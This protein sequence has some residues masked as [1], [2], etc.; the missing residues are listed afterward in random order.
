MKLPTHGFVDR[1]LGPPATSVWRDWPEKTGN[2]GSA[3]V[4]L[5]SALITAINTLAQMTSLSTG[6]RSL[7]FL[8]RFV[9]RV[10]EEEPQSDYSPVEDDPFLDELLP[11]VRGTSHYFSVASV[12]RLYTAAMSKLRRM[13]TRVPALF[14]DTLIPHLTTLTEML[15]RAPAD[16]NAER[17]LESQILVVL[18]SLQD[19][20]TLIA[21]GFHSSGPNAAALCRT[22]TLR[23]RVLT[24]A[25]GGQGAMTWVT[26]PD[27]KQLAATVF[28][29]KPPDEE[30]Q[31]KTR[32]VIGDLDALEKASHCDFLYNYK[33]YS[34]FQ[35]ALGSVIP[36]AGFNDQLRNVCVSLRVFLAITYKNTA[37]QHLQARA[38]NAWRILAATSCRQRR[39]ALRRHRSTRQPA[40]G[41]LWQEF[42]A[43]DTKQRRAM[44]AEITSVREALLAVPPVKQEKVLQPRIPIRPAAGGVEREAELTQPKQAK[45]PAIAKLAALN[46]GPSAKATFPPP[47]GT[48]LEYAWR[49]KILDQRRDILVKVRLAWKSANPSP[50]RT[51]EVRPFLPGRTAIGMSILIE[52]A[53]SNGDANRQFLSICGS[54]NDHILTA[55][56]VLAEVCSI[57]TL[58]DSTAAGKWRGIPLIR[59]VVFGLRDYYTKIIEHVQAD[60]ADRFFLYADGIDAVDAVTTLDEFWNDPGVDDDV[61]RTASIACGYTIFDTD[62]DSPKYYLGNIRAANPSTDISQHLKDD[63]CTSAT[64]LLLLGIV[65]WCYNRLREGPTAT[66][67]A[68]SYPFP[69]LGGPDVATYMNSAATNVTRSAPIKTYTPT[70]QELQDR[71][72]ASAIPFR[73]HAYASHQWLMAICDVEAS[74]SSRGYH[75]SSIVAKLSSPLVRS[76]ENIHNAPVIVGPDIMQA[77]IA[78]VIPHSVNVPQSNVRIDKYSSSL[79]WTATVLLAPMLTEVRR[80][81]AANT[82]LLTAAG[83]LRRAWGAFI[84]TRPSTS[85]AAV[86]EMQIPTIQ[87]ISFAMV[88]PLLP[89]GIFD[90]GSSVDSATGAHHVAIRAIIKKSQL[91]ET[92]YTPETYGGACVCA[93]GGDELVGSRKR[94][95][96]G[97]TS[98]YESARDSADRLKQT[99]SNFMQALTPTSLAPRNITSGVTIRSPENAVTLIQICTALLMV[100]PATTNPF[101]ELDIADADQF[102]ERVVATVFWFLTGVGVAPPAADIAE[103]VRLYTGTG[104]SVRFVPGADVKVDAEAACS[105]LASTEGTAKVLGEALTGMASLAMFGPQASASELHGWGILLTAALAG[106]FS[107]IAYLAE[108]VG[109]S[110]GV[111]F[112]SP[113]LITDERLGAISLQSAFDAANLMLAK[114]SD[115]VCFGSQHAAALSACV[116]IGESADIGKFRNCSEFLRASATADGPAQLQTREMLDEYQQLQR[117]L[118]HVTGRMQ[119]SVETPNDVLEGFLERARTMPVTTIADNVGRMFEERMQVLAGAPL[120]FQLYTP[121]NPWLVRLMQNGIPTFHPATESMLNQMLDQA[122]AA[123]DMQFPKEFASYPE[124]QLQSDFTRIRNLIAN[125]SMPL[126]DAY[127]F[128]D[129]RIFQARATGAILWLS[130]FLAELIANWSATMDNGLTNPQAQLQLRARCM[131]ELMREFSDPASTLLGTTLQ[132]ATFTATASKG[133][134]KSPPGWTTNRL[135]GPLTD[136]IARIIRPLFSETDTTIDCAKIQLQTGNNLAWMKQM[137]SET[138]RAFTF[139]FG[140]ETAT[141]AVAKQIKELQEKLDTN[142]SELN[143][144]SDGK[145]VDIYD[146]T[147]STAADAELAAANSTRLGAIAAID[148]ELNGA[149][150]AYESARTKT[151]EKGKQPA[152]RELFVGQARKTMEYLDTATK[153]GIR[154]FRNL[155]K[156]A[157]TIRNQTLAEKGGVLAREVL[158]RMIAMRV[159]ATE[160]VLP[161]IETFLANYYR[162][163]LEH[164]PQRIP[165]S[166]YPSA[167][168][169][170][171]PELLPEFDKDCDYHCFLEVA[172]FNFYVDLI[173]RMAYAGINTFSTGTVPTLSSALNGMIEAVYSRSTMSRDTLGAFIAGFTTDPVDWVVHNN[174][175]ATTDE[176]WIDPDILMKQDVLWGQWAEKCFDS[177]T[178]PNFDTAEKREALAALLRVTGA[179]HKS[180]WERDAVTNA[181]LFHR[182]FDVVGNYLLAEGG[183][184]IAISARVF[185]SEDSAAEMMKYQLDRCQEGD[186]RNALAANNAEIVLE[187]NTTGIEAGPSFNASVYETFSVERQTEL[188]QR[189]TENEPQVTEFTKWKVAEEKARLA[190]EKAEATFREVENRI[191]GERIAKLRTLVP[192]MVIATKA[193]QDA[194]DAHVTER[195]DL[196]KQL[197]ELR[198][199]FKHYETNMQ[200]EGN[201]TLDAVQ[202]LPSGPTID[203]YLYGTFAPVPPPAPSLRQ[204]AVGLLTNAAISVFPAVINASVRGIQEFEYMQGGALFVMGA[205]MRSM[206][207]WEAAQPARSGKRKIATDIMSSLANLFGNTCVGEKFVFGS[208]TA[209]LA[210]DPSDNDLPI[211]ATLQASQLMSWAY[212]GNVGGGLVAALSANLSRWLGTDPAD[213]TWTLQQVI[214]GYGLASFFSPEFQPAALLIVT[215]APRAMSHSWNQGVPKILVP[216]N[217]LAYVREKMPT[218]FAALVLQGLVGNDVGTTRFMRFARD[219]ALLDTADMQR[220]AS[221]VLPIERLFREYVFSQ[222]GETS[223]DERPLPLCKNAWQKIGAPLLLTAI[224]TLVIFI[225][226]YLATYDL[227]PSDSGI[228]LQRKNLARGVALI[229]MTN[230]I[231][232]AEVYASAAI[233]ANL[234][235]KLASVIRAAGDRPWTP[236]EQS[237]FMSR[238]YTGYLFITAALVLGPN[239]I[240]DWIAGPRPRQFGGRMARGL[241]EALALGPDWLQSSGSVSEVSASFS[242]WIAFPATAFRNLFSLEELGP[243]L[244]SNLYEL[245]VT[246]PQASIARAH[247]GAVNLLYTTA[248]TRPAQDWYVQAE[249]ATLILLVI[250]VAVNLARGKSPGKGQLQIPAAPRKSSR[251]GKE[252][253]S[254][255]I[256]EELQESPG[257]STFFEWVS[258]HKTISAAAGGVLG[259]LGVTL[260][261]AGG[262]KIWEAY[263]SPKTDIRDSL[264]DLMFFFYTRMINVGILF[265]LFVLMRYALRGWI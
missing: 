211:T 99:C 82:C 233:V 135:H 202:K 16:S 95:G 29:K 28:S 101:A 15:T 130:N 55:G 192:G 261:N 164:I 45:N 134:P 117:Y 137:R 155:V 222:Y 136:A 114:S 165:V 215:I 143:R 128:R 124:M 123:I 147:W 209:F 60:A 65:V 105:S 190:R 68:G 140:S 212:P 11:Y 174:D 255:S 30:A 264:T 208:Q 131:F 235:T 210:V 257:S 150:V 171:Q 81:G 159:R 225:P 50:I 1:V 169:L 75:I 10:L 132:F 3:N 253:A 224:K 121:E 244:G 250:G 204:S 22:S 182:I 162:K 88:H 183:P 84:T 42:H 70:W 52:A 186:F 21:T 12:L 51:P 167:V 149:K 145:Y 74:G 213:I 181:T 168:V 180:V 48:G 46:T 17:T 265:L 126:T 232:A 240:I 158:D 188:A 214:A 251:K 33:L 227:P 44:L 115:V 61:F 27:R 231:Q 177:T 40:P 96:V 216:A 207:N 113:Q 53:S 203:S 79:A 78:S 260:L 87:Q 196:L 220:I 36:S 205:L 6:Q 73:A 125:W 80:L 153:E 245:V 37:P 120:A 67:T 157:V 218:F 230:L 226:G 7:L 197:G 71:A 144:L 2:L 13:D 138:N 146:A 175:L 199:D 94:W 19:L 20:A 72:I 241:S 97:L 193:D 221:S 139:W 156:P 129:D 172:D 239:A 249:Y 23:S 185:L 108:G 76:S 118:Q 49:K 178:F 63:S 152:G 32:M 170:R 35:E 106:G 127:E 259:I 104:G 111:S 92:L 236:A 252:P 86:T 163:G 243:A 109:F 93:H 247:V 24:R 85:D 43:R 228:A 112:L 89:A 184:R 133:G 100:M 223:R 256:A 4:P 66:H 107:G 91:S 110:L 217:L 8:M 179:A 62:V 38:T 18:N 14:V 201:A 151:R 103:L 58:R 191:A 142:K 41:R 57:S 31:T 69:G 258:E 5:R 77:I 26:S 254:A 54:T 229:Q 59:Q 166:R 39:D 200:R 242:K 262:E 198:V 83:F 219:V 160:L 189:A 25:A 148:T 263:D 187:F 237:H 246:R 102:V 194:F 195:Q 234:L 154:D 206:W 98:P 238:A 119:I 141:R 47:P 34:D 64:R 248:E 173:A 176:N 56:F 90:P 116:S 9:L 161:D 122:A